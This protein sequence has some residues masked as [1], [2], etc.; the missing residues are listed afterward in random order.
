MYVC[1]YVCKLNFLISFKLQTLKELQIKILNNNLKEEKK[2][3]KT[4][5]EKAK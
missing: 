3:R 2:N 5:Y 1:M 4:K